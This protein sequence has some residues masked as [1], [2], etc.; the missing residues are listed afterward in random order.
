MVPA[1]AHEEAA[2][3]EVASRALSQM[4]SLKP[5]AEPRGACILHQA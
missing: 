5:P 4:Y 1:S 3:N 2:G